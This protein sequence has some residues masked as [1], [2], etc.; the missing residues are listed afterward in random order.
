MLQQC[1][2]L[3]TMND[4]LAEHELRIE[5]RVTSAG[6]ASSRRG[7]GWLRSLTIGREW[8]RERAAKSIRT[9]SE[10]PLCQSVTQFFKAAVPA[11]VERKSC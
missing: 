1:Q 7:G 9:T 3:Y 10:R 11:R 5:L 4:D 8:E 6:A 2:Q